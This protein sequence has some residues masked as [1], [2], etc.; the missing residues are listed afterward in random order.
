MTKRASGQFERRQL[1]HYP[2]PAA[3]VAPLIP[4]L[5]RT[6]VKTFVEPCCAEGELVDHLEKEGLTCLMRGDIREGQPYGAIPFDARAWKKS[7]FRKADATI[8]NPP[9][10]EPMLSEIMEHQSIFV[11]SWFLIYSDWLFTRQ[12]SKLMHERCTDIVPIGRVKWFPESKSVGYDNCCWVR[13]DLN[14]QQDVVF[15][16]M[17]GAA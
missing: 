3:A 16:P 11:P 17:R 4:H 8:T 1:D 6:G 15:W 2:T 5:A 7:D 9:W 10:K 13:M 14:K 12:S